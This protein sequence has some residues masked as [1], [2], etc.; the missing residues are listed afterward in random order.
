MTTT[1]TPLDEAALE[2][3]FE[4]A[5]DAGLWNDLMTTYKE[6][7]AVAIH[8]YIAHAPKLELV[9]WSYD[10]AFSYQTGKYYEWRSFVSKDKPCV[11]E[12]SIRNLIPLYAGPVL[13]DKP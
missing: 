12:G 6:S 10:L 13:E 7:L 8:A 5:Y 9:A 11:P 2:A 4:A 3:A 1:P